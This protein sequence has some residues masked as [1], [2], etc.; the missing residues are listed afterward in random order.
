MSS[1][2]DPRDPRS[3][4]DDLS[5]LVREVIGFSTSVGT[6][7]AQLD[8]HKETLQRI[9]TLLVR[10]IEEKERENELKE[11]TLKLRELE[12]KRRNRDGG[13]NHEFRMRLLTAGGGLLTGSIVPALL[14]YFLGYSAPVV[15]PTLTHVPEV[16]DVPTP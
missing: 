5:V 1:P 15:P 8:A 7:V 12:E 4:I 16:S 9:Q 14:W 3:V 13:R 2:A 10:L 11:E 6:R